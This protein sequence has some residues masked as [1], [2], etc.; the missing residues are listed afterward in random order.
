MYAEQYKIREISLDINLCKLKVD[1]EIRNNYRYYYKIIFITTFC[2]N[3][4]ASLAT[5]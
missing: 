2:R 1:D 4:W 5:T 3:I